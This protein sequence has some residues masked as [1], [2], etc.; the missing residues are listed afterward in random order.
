LTGFVGSAA[1]DGSWLRDSGC[2]CSSRPEDV[3]AEVV[4][5]VK[6]SREND[7]TVSPAPTA[8][9]NRKLVGG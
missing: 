3:D 4:D 1:A 5:D 7:G 8:D 2:C 9:G 6:I